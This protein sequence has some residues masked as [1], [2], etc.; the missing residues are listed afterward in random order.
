M[1]YK[2]TNKTKSVASKKKAPKGII[3]YKPQI[4]RY[5]NM[6]NP[7][8][9]KQLSAIPELYA[10]S[11][12]PTNK[13]KVYMKFFIGGWTWY[14]LELDQKTKN[15]AFAYVVSPMENVYG[16][17]SLKEL[18]S[19]KKDFLRVDRDTYVSPHQPK[20]LVD[21]VKEDGNP[22]PVV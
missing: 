19:V 20:K 5:K 13:K 22:L 2:R 6:W 17:V 1:S 16:Y 4:K 9:D 14:I 10:Q 11:E 12:V 7:P 15:D 8:T 21:V 3:S 18:D